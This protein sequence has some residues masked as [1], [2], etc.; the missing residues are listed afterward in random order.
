M[1]SE[2]EPASLSEPVKT[3]YSRTRVNA[4]SRDPLSHSPG[5][6]VRGFRTPDIS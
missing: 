1:A 4:E 3:F 6:S 2:E 5:E